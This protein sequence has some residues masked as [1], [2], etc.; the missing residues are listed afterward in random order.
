MFH[1]V[2]RVAVEQVQRSSMK[3]NSTDFA[4]NETLD[5]KCLNVQKSD[6]LGELPRL[7][8]VNSYILHG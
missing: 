2:E 3:W 4:S 8:S 6:E 5:T 1:N 7:R